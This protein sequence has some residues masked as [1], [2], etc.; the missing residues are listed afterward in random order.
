MLKI[1]KLLPCDVKNAS[2]IFKIRVLRYYIFKEYKCGKE[3]HE[4]VLGSKRCIWSLF[5][6]E[7]NRVEN[8]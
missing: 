6:I 1:F 8:I 3:R 2:K 4:R 7:Q 5:S